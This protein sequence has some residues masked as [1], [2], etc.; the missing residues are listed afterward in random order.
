MQHI[1]PYILFFV[2]LLVFFSCTKEKTID[3]PPTHETNSITQTNVLEK[4]LG[5]YSLFDRNWNLMEYTI[6]LED[7]VFKAKITYNKKTSVTLLRLV[8]L[9][10]N[11]YSFEYD[12]KTYYLRVDNILAEKRTI[13]ILNEREE[14]FLNFFEGKGF[15]DLS[16]QENRKNQTLRRKLDISSF[17][18]PIRP[19]KKNWSSDMNYTDTLQYI[20]FDDVSNPMRAIFTTN[21]RDTVYLSFEIPIGSEF[22]GST[23]EVR[24]KIDTVLVNK[25]PKLNQKLLHYRVVR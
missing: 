14:R 19:T 15:V 7:S 21:T 1:K 11:L 20:S 22:N 18:S 10:S 16:E 4:V 23:M 12:G 13:R 24:W 17:F 8:D 3:T 9:S 2:F 25:L 5:T 6:F